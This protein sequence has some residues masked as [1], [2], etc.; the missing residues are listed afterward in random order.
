MGA[1]NRFHRS[2]KEWIAAIE[3]DEERAFRE[4]FFTFHQPLCKFAARYIYSA[5]LAEEVVQEVFGQVWEKRKKLD[6]EQSIK[7]LLYQSVRN[8]TLDF[9][10][11][12]KTEQKYLDKLKHDRSTTTEHP[13][14][15]LQ[16]KTRFEAAAKQAIKELPERGHRIYM[17]SRKDGLTYKEIAQV[18]DI[19]PKTVESHMSRSLKKLRKKLKPYLTVILLAIS[20]AFLNL[21]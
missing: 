2:S 16:E 14:V 17:L 1:D 15:T 20:T 10:R 19:S 18:L 4:L 5:H 13:E 21:L 3:K 11:R 6:P 9:Q 8:K 12:R 7:A